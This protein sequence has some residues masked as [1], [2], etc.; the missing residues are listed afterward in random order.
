MSIRRALPKPMVRPI[1]VTSAF[2]IPRGATHLGPYVF[3]EH[4]MGLI[5]LFDPDDESIEQLRDE[6]PAWLR[7]I[8]D[9][10]LRQRSFG[11]IF[12][13]F[14]PRCEEWTDWEGK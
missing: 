8:M 14:S 12:D 10:A 4:E 5:I 6:E 13:Y 7:P 2:H 11:I 1:L 9:A 3:A